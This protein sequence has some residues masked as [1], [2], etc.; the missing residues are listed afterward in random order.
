MSVFAKAA[1]PPSVNELRSAGVIVTDS[2]CYSY[3][4]AIIRTRSGMSL[5]NAAQAAEAEATVQLLNNKR[6]SKITI[7]ADLE[8]HKRSLFALFQALYPINATQLVGISVLNRGQSDDHAWCVLSLPA[9]SLKEIEEYTGSAEDILE[10]NLSRLP[11]R[12]S[13]A[14]VYEC[15]NAKSKS[16]AD[17]FLRGWISAVPNISSAVAGNDLECIPE[18]WWVPNNKFSST[19]LNRMH[20]LELLQLLD[21]SL[22]IG[23]ARSAILNEFRKRGFGG[24]SDHLAKIIPAEFP[25]EEDADSRILLSHIE[26]KMTDIHGPPGDGLIRFFLSK[27]AFAPLLD[28]RQSQ[29]KEWIEALRLFGQPQ[30][31][32]F[33]EVYALCIKSIAISPTSDAFNLA[34][35]CLELEGVHLT[36]ALWFYGQAHH[37]NPDHPFAAANIAMLLKKQGNDILSNIIKDRALNNVNLPNDVR[38]QLL[39]IFL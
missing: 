27:N 32:D 28:H 15:L 18:F 24:F 5:A 25:L 4:S 11:P 38:R 8:K 6:F 30:G 12:C 33:M 21:S 16:R 22:M 19:D 34:G 2:F 17:Q 1:L 23:S 37:M 35:K 29:Q 26:S 14:L 20:D 31:Q 7:P 13:P 39:D 9:D 3:G 10:E 36:Q